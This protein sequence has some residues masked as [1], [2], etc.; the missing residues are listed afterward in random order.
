MAF[1]F[2]KDFVVKFFDSLI[3]NNQIIPRRNVNL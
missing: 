1:V 2:F 3:K